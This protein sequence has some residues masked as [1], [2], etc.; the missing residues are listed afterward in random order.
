MQQ[1]SDASLALYGVNSGIS[2]IEF[3]HKQDLVPL[4]S[5]KLD[6]VNILCFGI[7]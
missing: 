5:G 7:Y 6:A 1:G 3:G 4:G 2:E